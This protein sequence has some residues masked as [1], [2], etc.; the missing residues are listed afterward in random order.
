MNDFSR[1]ETVGENTRTEQIVEAVS[2]KTAVTTSSVS[3][4]AGAASPELQSLVARSDVATT[5]PNIAGPQFPQFPLSSGRSKSNNRQVKTFYLK[6]QNC[7]PSID[8]LD[9]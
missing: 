5:P 9:D 8:V 7:L 1:V 2:S 3:T 4:V 6:L